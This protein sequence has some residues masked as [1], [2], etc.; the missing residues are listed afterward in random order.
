[1]L[2][3]ALALL[4]SAAIVVVTQPL[5]AF[6][7]LA[8]IFPRIL[9]RVETNAPLVALTFDDGPAPDHTPQVLDILARRQAHA[10]FF[11]IGERAAAHP[12]LVSRIRGAGHEVGNHSLTVRSILRAS[13]TEFASNLERTEQILDLRGPVKLYR[14][15]G[16]R[17]RPSQLT[18]AL[19]RGYTCVLGSA[20]PYDP[21]HPPSSYIRWLVT[22]NLAPGVIVILH[23]GI[24]DPSRTFAALEG[25]LEAGQAKGLRFVT[26]SGLL[27]ARDPSGRCATRRP[28]G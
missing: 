3:V 1:V 13:E 27:A 2:L 23:D 21:A 22:K 10:T 17:M 5:A 7:V 12:N 4:S 20:Y 24:A 11:L 25:I 14:P 18:H 28:S 26:V 8:W 16:G 19:R 6:H 15:P 9:W